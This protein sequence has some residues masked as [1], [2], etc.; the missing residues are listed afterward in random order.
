MPAWTRETL[1]EAAKAAYPHL[2]PCFIEPLVE[3]WLSSPDTF[4]AIVRHDM[5]R[6][7]KNK[8][9]N[10]TATEPKQSLFENA[11]R[12]GRAENTEPEPELQKSGVTVEELPNGQDGE[13]LA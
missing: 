8:A 4:N 12:V 10:R 6:E 9:K 1:L 3:L 11:V 2:K 5:K 7:A 13:S